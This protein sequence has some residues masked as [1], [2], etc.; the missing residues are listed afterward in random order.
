MYINKFAMDFYLNNYRSCKMVADLDSEFGKQ[1]GNLIQIKNFQ[2]VLVQVDTI[3]KKE[4][5]EVRVD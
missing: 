3:S 1:I 2:S 4:L 5:K